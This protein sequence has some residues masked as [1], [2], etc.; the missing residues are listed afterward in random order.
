MTSASEAPTASRDARISRWVRPNCLHRLQSLQSVCSSAPAR[1]CTARGLA[2]QR[3][4]SGQAA[5]LQGV[6]LRRSEDH[7]RAPT[8]GPQCLSQMSASLQL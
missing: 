7:D 1:H 2:C 8:S 3:P 6:Q 5:A 4:R